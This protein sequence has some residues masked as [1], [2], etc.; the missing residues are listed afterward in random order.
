MLCLSLWFLGQIIIS[1]FEHAKL[2]ISI[3]RGSDLISM[4]LICNYP[5]DF[6]IQYLQFHWRPPIVN[7]WLFSSGYC[8]ITPMPWK[9]FTNNPCPQGHHNFRCQESSCTMHITLAAL[10]WNLIS[11]N[12]RCLRCGQGTKNEERSK[13][14]DKDE[15]NSDDDSE[16]FNFEK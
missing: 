16:H 12:S 5:P 13:A 10:S 6:M 11:E 15:S 9:K 7:K 4:K 8:L 1:V 2:L 14:K 3:P